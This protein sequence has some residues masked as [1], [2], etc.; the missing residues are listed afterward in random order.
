MVGGHSRNG[1]PA[2]WR[3]PFA[4]T[5]LHPGSASVNFSAGGPL[6]EPPI[7]MDGHP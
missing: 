7:E 2:A 6:L 4:H 3:Q 5:F 1:S